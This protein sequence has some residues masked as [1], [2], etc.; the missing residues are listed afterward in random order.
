MKNSARYA[1]KIK[2]LL[3]GA[4]KSDRTDQVDLIPLLV[5][6]VLEEDAAAKQAAAG[7]VILEEEFVDLN[8]LRVSP[9]KDIVECLERGFP[10]ARLKAEAMTGALNAVFERNNAL[11]LEYLAEKTK[12]E[13][14]RALREEL[15]L[16]LYAESVLTL[17]GFD[18]HAIPVDELLLEALKLNGYIHPDSDLADLQGFLERIILNKDAV[19][20]H[21]AFRAYASKAA[22][23]VVRVLARRAKEAQ[24]AERARA[25]AEAKAKAEAEAS[26]K[27][28]AAKKAAKK[29]KK[30]PRK[31]TESRRRKRLKAAKKTRAR[32]A[33]RKAAPM[34]AKK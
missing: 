23:R 11:S 18:G 8:E 24:E 4:K 5:K 14:R 22:K 21:E 3:S 10:K 25:A 12:R 27:K 13:V 15:G 31:K 29:A 7:L 34:R 1:R 16:S 9:I 30:R 26:K 19:A 33:A 32:A 28:A 17:Y 6:A 20:A 2:R